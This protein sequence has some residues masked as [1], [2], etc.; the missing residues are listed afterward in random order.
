MHMKNLMA[1]IA[2]LAVT[3]SGAEAIAEPA[4]PAPAE[5]KAGS[6]AA[7]KHGRHRPRPF[8]EVH[9]A[10]DRFQIA[11]DGIGGWHGLI[12]RAEVARR[13]AER[14]VHVQAQRHRR[15]VTFSLLYRYANHY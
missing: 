15:G 5:K 6:P 9:F 12:K 13:R 1:V 11:I 14:H 2:V 7:P 8:D 3:V 10:R 4:A